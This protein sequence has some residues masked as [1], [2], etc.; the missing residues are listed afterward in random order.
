MEFNFSGTFYVNEEEIKEICNYVKN[1]MGIQTA[2][3]CWAEGLDDV[4]F[5]SVGRIEEDLAREIKKRVEN[6]N[7]T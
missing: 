5:Y 1:G 4:D 7:P 3:N 2:I 6:G